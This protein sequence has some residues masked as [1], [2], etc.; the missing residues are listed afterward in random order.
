MTSGMRGIIHDL[1]VLERAGMPAP[2]FGDRDRLALRADLISRRLE[3]KRR[4]EKAER[5]RRREERKKEK[6]ALR[7]RRNRER[8]EREAFERLEVLCPEAV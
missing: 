4:L 7:H 6:A 2:E 5:R 8:E 1:I 3:E